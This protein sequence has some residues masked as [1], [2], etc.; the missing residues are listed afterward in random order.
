MQ[1]V[2]I[3]DAYS[4][5]DW[6]LT[7]LL[8][9]VELVFM[10][11]LSDD[12]AKKKAATLHAASGLMTINGYPGE[13][14]VHGDSHVLWSLWAFFMCQFLHVVYELLVGTHRCEVI[15]AAFPVLD[16]CELVTSS[17]L[18]PWDVE[19]DL[20]I[21][22]CSQALSMTSSESCSLACPVQRIQR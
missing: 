20:H 15:D 21:L 4:C 6:L 19:G 18:S 17:Y 7:F 8:L 2:L 1:Y 22:V 16:S 9:L 13:L 12:E 14:I 5:M 11:R 3:S 10:M